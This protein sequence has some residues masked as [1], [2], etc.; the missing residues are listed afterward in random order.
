MKFLEHLIKK[1]DIFQRTVGL[2]LKQFE[3]LAKQLVNPWQK[4]EKQRKMSAKRKRKIGGGRPY[5]L[6]NL[7]LKLLTVLVYYKSYSTQE[8]LGIL[9]GLDQANVSRL[10]AKMRPLIEQATD[11][12]LTTYL[13]KVKKRIRAIMPTA[14]H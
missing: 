5:K 8:F 7:K 10:L 4:A 11:S 2:N 13:N 14:T 9:I 12:E 6:M 1:P 3:L